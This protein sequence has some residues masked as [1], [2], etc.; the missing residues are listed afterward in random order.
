LLK[1]SL[2]YLQLAQHHIDLALELLN[3]LGEKMFHEEQWKDK[4]LELPQVLGVDDLTHHGLLIRVWFRTA[5]LQQWSVGREFRYRVRKIF[6]ENNI[7]ISKPQ[8]VTYHSQFPFL[9]SEK[10]DQDELAS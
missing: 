8:L 10:N 1:P 3:Q 6:A 9:D 4:I 7:E 5:P 2:H